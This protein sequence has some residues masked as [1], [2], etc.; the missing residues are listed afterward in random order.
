MPDHYKSNASKGKKEDKG[1]RWEKSD[2]DKYA[3][4]KGDKPT[5]KQAYHDKG[6]QDYYSKKGKK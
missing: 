5:K 6:M 3:P 2:W 1:N 4:R